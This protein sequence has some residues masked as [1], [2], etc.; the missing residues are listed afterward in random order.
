MDDPQT[1]AALGSPNG[2][3]VAWLLG[4]HKHQLGNKY[5]DYVSLSS[6]FAEVLADTSADVGLRLF[7]A[8]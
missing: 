1:K 7:W 2:K 5:I 8:V 4:Q 3:G 6:P